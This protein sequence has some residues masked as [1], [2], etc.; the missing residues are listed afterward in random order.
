MFSVKLKL[1]ICM[2]G[3]IRTMSVKNDLEL[4]FE[5]SYAC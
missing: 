1:T 3:H 4:L 5:Q 2:V